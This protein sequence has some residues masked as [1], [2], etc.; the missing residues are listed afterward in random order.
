M[1]FAP[2]TEEPYKSGSPSRCFWYEEKEKLKPVSYRWNVAM[3]TQE[4]QQSQRN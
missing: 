1:S 2:A 4:A 3:G